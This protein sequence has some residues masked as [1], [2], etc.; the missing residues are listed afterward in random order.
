MA[1]PKPEREG[2]GWFADQ[3][4]DIRN[5][6]REQSKASGTQKANAVRRLFEAFEE[7]ERQQEVINAQQADL[8]GRLAYSTGSKEKVEWGTPVEISNQAFGPPLSFELDRPRVVSITYQ[9]SVFATANAPDAGSSANSWLN[10][11]IR[12]DGVLQDFTAHGSFGVVASYGPGADKGSVSVGLAAR[13][14]GILGAGGHVVQGT[15]SPSIAVTGSGSG[16]VEAAE[17]YLFVD[18]LQPA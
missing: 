13:W 12:V 2:A 1:D 4:A 7:L 17:P 3:F 6:Q 15:L 8:L 9:M 16:Y 10:S 18:V 5:D 11:R 14:L